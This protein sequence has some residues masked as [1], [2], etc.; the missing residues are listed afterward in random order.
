M[1]EKLK[2]KVFDLA[3]KGLSMKRIAK[4]C[5]VKRKRVAAILK[6]ARKRLTETRAAPGFQA[7]GIKPD[8][9]E[10][11]QNQGLIAPPLIP[12]SQRLLLPLTRTEMVMHSAFAELIRRVHNRFERFELHLLGPGN[13][14]PDTALAISRVLQQR[15]ADVTLEIT[16][17]SSLINADL[18]VFLAGDTRILRSD[19]WIVFEKPSSTPSSRHARP[20]ASGALC[21][22]Y[23]TDYHQVYDGIT[24]ILPAQLA[25]R[26]IHASELSEWLVDTAPEWETEIPSIT[27][28][29]TE[30]LANP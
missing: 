25:G 19:A 16:A 28:E 23:Q 14:L 1:T 15:P 8:W 12:G 9:L 11:N 13:I 26:R 3:L 22:G 10:P 21:T 18:L 24:R 30:S 2:H 17:H 5:G 20:G 6:T 4:R 27:Q 7:L 29:P